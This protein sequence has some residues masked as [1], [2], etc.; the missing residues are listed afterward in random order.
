[1][2]KLLNV[3]EPLVPV[4]TVVVLPVANEPLLRVSVIG[5]L[6]EATL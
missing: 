6:L 5:T 2:A 3:A 1:M 4:F